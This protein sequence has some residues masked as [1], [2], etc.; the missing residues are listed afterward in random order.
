M[1]WLRP[2]TQ[3]FHLAQPHSRFYQC[4]DGILQEQ[5]SRSNMD[6]AVVIP[7]HPPRRW[8]PDSLN[9]ESSADA[10]KSVHFPI[11]PPLTHDRVFM[12]AEARRYL[13]SNCAVSWVHRVPLLLVY[14]T[15]TKKLI[16]IAGG[17]VLGILAYAIT[18]VCKRTFRAFA[19]L[20]P[21]I[22][23]ARSCS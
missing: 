14:P 18:P 5:S 6:K 15:S 21:A 19:G 23:C 12:V 17:K 11:V 7:K 1:S 20:S 16:Y 10:F 3:R 9:S 8:I 4:R 13:H 2:V 22:C